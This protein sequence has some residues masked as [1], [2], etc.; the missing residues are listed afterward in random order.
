MEDDALAEDLRQVIG[1]LV[2]AV[3]AADTM[4]SGEAAIL[5][6]LDRGGPRTTADLAHLRGVTH[7]AA[8]K[9]VKEL[10]GDGLVRAEPHPRDGRKLLLHITDIGR[11]RLQR[12]RAQRATWL[13]AAIRDTLSP[14]EQQRLRECV[15]LLARLTTRMTGR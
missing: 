4:P 3:R 15:S 13:D 2:R 1:D 9:S 8:A 5:G 14:E 12:E 7:Q 6:H 11:A 10:L